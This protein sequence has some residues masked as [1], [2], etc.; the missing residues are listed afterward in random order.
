A[1][2]EVAWMKEIVAAERHVM[3]LGKLR[4]RSTGCVDCEVWHPGLAQI[5]EPGPQPDVDGG[6]PALGKCGQIRRGRGDD[7]RVGRGG[8]CAFL[9]HLGDEVLLE[10]HGDS[11]RICSISKSSRFFSTSSL[12]TRSLFSTS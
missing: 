5:H 9:Q 6:G 3:S 10:D 1:E 4:L 7:E 11:F 2:D 12:R 8:I